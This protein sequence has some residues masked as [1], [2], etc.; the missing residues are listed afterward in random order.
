MRQNKRRAFLRIEEPLGANM[1]TLNFLWFR[2]GLLFP[3]LLLGSLFVAP[4]RAERL[5]FK[6]YSTTEGLAHDSVNKIVRDSRGFLWFCTGEGLSRFD[7]SKFTNYTQDQGL[8]SRNINDLFE[9]RDGTYLIATSAG[10]TVFNPNGKAYRWNLLE[11]K[12]EY[13]ADHNSSEPPLFQ[14]FVPQTDDPQAKTILTLAQDLSGTIWAGT[15]NGL[16]QFK[17]EG[18][19]W[20][21]HEFS[22]ERKGT[23]YPALFADSKGNVI[24]GSGRAIYQLSPA[25]DLKKVVD[26]GAN[27]FL[28]DREGRIWVGS[29][30]NPDGLRVLTSENGTLRLATTYTS[31]DG[32]PAEGFIFALKQTSTGRIFAGLAN[33]LCEFLPDARG[34]EPKFRV[35]EAEKVL[36]LAEDSGGSLWLGTELKGAWK[37]ARSGFVSFGE[38]DGISSQDT[39]AAIYANR[40]GELFIPKGPRGTLHLVGGKFESVLPSN[41]PVRTW[42]WHFL[43]LQSQDGEWWIPASTGLWRYPK[44]A[45]FADLAHTPPKKVYTRA[46]G[47][48]TSEVFNL[49]EDSRGD[50]WM[51]VISG[52]N[53]LVRWERKTERIITYTTADGLPQGNGAISFAEDSH[54][55]VWFGFYFGG[56]RRYRNGKF[57]AFTAK[58]GIPEGMVIDLLADSSGRLWI[59][60]NSRGLFRVDRPEE[61]TPAFTS[62]STS[63]GLSSNQISCLTEDRFKRIYVGTGYGINRID[64]NG[65]VKLFTQEDG[66]PGNY[67][68]RCGSDKR[69]ALW[70]VARN[71]L[72]RFVPEIEQAPTP[73][74]VLIDR[75]VINGI[76]QRIS[77][78]GETE[79]GQLELESNQRQ[80]QVDFFALTFGAEQNISYQY[81][82]DNH[83]WSN[84]TKQQTLNLDLAPGKH[85]LLVRA[86][87]TDGI[88]S[89]KPAII[90]FRILPPL[91]LRW[92][93]MALTIL[94]VLTVL[95]LIYRYRMARLREVN[96]ALA[97]AKRAEENLGKAR[98][99]RLAELERVRTRIATDLHDDIGA[100]LTQIAI[101]SEVAQQQNK[102][103]S[104]AVAQ[105]L[106]IISSVSNELVGTMS[107]IVWAINPQ[108]DHLRDLTQRMRRF[109]SDLLSA[110]GIAF[111]FNAPTTDS[112]IPLGA[113]LRREVFLIFKESLNNI[114]KHSSA[115]RANIELNFSDEHLTLK[116]A[117]NG[118]GFES[119]KNTRALFANDRGGNGI[120]SMERRAREINGTLEITSAVGKGAVV[121]LRLPMSEPPAA[122]GG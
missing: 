51:T 49:F 121:T 66:L 118:N 58:D 52:A 92:W 59:A 5:P 39:L 35:V 99:E 11:S 28:E 111:E 64:L 83:D 96:V 87:R 93:F 13:D 23:G 42:G 70:F 18:A 33:G 17:K 47:L 76:R 106:Q 80:I 22:L 24:I 19:A 94:L 102:A 34:S 6:A 54:G 67:V 110:K 62:I 14:T 25:G 77:E 2:L 82:L 36:T 95:Y 37:M 97:E 65:H 68:T 73:P 116:I 60:T 7:G 32:L 43:D 90:S 69:G 21:F 72:I 71:A 29:G 78:L 79:I 38:K 10:L 74:P 85:S 98:E 109:A 26:G 101:L 107:D 115:T 16:F 4:M 56:L 1:R 20:Q 86:V 108:R 122:A 103:S 55:S 9:T 105:P 63:N 27:S 120:F 57:Q 46:D 100:S 3:S 12:L 61:E 81:Q 114:V 88:A 91:W 113:N 117:D 89:E 31:K 84:P 53:S 104:G 119:E 50:I 44:V 48:F 75:V 40:D 30:G 15:L 112:D 41:Y 8:P 45:T